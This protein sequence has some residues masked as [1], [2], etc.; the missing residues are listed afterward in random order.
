MNRKGIALL[1]AVMA[2]ALL[3]AVSA[4]AFS[5]AREEARIGREALATL[6]ARSAAEASAVA[7]LGGWRRELTPIVP[8]DSLV[9]PPVSAGGDEG[10]VVVRALGGS[11]L[12]LESTGRAGAPGGTSQARIRLQ[13]LVRLDSAECDSLVYPRR[14]SR[15]WRVIP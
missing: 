15:G 6:H 12:A 3:G 5:L 1:L 11:I 10:T 7:A 9:L 4:T 8:G 2:L 13:L 14:I